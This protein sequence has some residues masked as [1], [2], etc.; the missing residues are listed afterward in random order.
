MGTKVIVRA[1]HVLL[2]QKV[3]RSHQGGAVHVQTIA[4]DSI[5]AGTEL[6]VEADDVRGQEHK[7]ERVSPVLVRCGN[8]RKEFETTMFSVEKISCPGCGGAHCKIVGEVNPPPIHQAPPPK[9]ENRM[10]KRDLV[11]REAEKRE[12]EKVEK[13]KQAR[14]LKKD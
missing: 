9:V 6:E 4:G 3:V 10:E 11:E 8:C 5:K 14:I 1:P 2:K 12:T 7:I 13:E